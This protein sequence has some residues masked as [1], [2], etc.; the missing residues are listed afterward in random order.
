MS[1]QKK[2]RPGRPRGRLLDNKLSFNLEQQ[3]FDSIQ[4]RSKDTNETIS[5]II[6]KA[7]KTEMQKYDAVQKKANSDALFTT[8]SHFFD[9]VVSRL[10]KF[11][12]PEP[13]NNLVKGTCKKKGIQIIAF[14]KED[15]KGDFADSL[16]NMLKEIYPFKQ[17]M[18]EQCKFELLKISE[19]N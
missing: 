15:L 4:T 10:E 9:L 2:R 18:I 12:G 16:C 19:E 7:L 6:T 17:Q 1:K 14:C 5:Q 8:P 13:A 11:I 3:L